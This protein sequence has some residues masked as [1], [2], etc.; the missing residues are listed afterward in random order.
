MSYLS[1][2]P[3]GTG[4]ISWRVRWREDGRLQSET[5]TSKPDAVVFRGMVDAAGQR[6]PARW[7]PGQGFIDTPTDVPTLREWA[8]RAIDSRP[9]A[10]ERTRAAYRSQ[11]AQHVPD[12]LLDTPLDQVTRERVGAWVI[13]LSSRRAPKTVRNIHG[14]LSSL[15]A[16]AVDA[17]LI[18]RNPIKGLVTALPDVHAEEPVF[19]TPDEL[20]LILANIDQHYRPLVMFL[21]RTGCR[22]GEATAIDVGSVDLE[23][24]TVRIDRAVKRSAQGTF[25]IGSPKS[26]RSKRTITLDPQLVDALRPL[27]AGRHHGLLFRTHEGQRVSHSNFYGRKWS[28]A[29]DSASRCDTHP[30]DPCTCPGVLRRRPRVHD[31]RH[32]HASWLI[33]AGVPL[34]IVQARLGHESIKTT[35]DLYGHLAEDADRVAAEAMAML[36]AAPIPRQ[37]RLA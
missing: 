27:T 26:R 16:D 33:A 19:L 11:I 8:Q 23:H 3:T 18:A 14:L 6:W 4:Q 37:L 9:R 35:V 25:Y 36:D 1:K 22:F 5:F 32:S 12:D 28:T 34:P 17:G 13:D 7:I 30:T 20:R 2:R 31:L 15:F 10:N 29:L 21:A 24:A